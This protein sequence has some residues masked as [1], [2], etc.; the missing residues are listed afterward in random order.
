MDVCKYLCTRDIESSLHPINL[1]IITDF[2]VV[3]CE[4]QLLN[5]SAKGDFDAS[6][7][8]QY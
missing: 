4:F 2:S 7:K 1:T 6:I 3:V 8:S 5:I